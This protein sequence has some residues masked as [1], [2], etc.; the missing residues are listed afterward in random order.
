MHYK[1]DILHVLMYDVTC[2]I[3]VIFY[4]FWCT[5]SFLTILFGEVAVFNLQVCCRKWFDN[6][7]TMIIMVMM[8][9]GIIPGG[10]HSNRSR[11]EGAEWTRNLSTTFI[12]IIVKRVACASGLWD[13]VTESSSRPNTSLGKGTHFVF[14]SASCN[15]EWS[16]HST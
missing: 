1:C 8:M 15:Q 2:M 14:P 16:V 6:F 9:M 3:N 4:K 10:S 13:A 11:I 7:I 5:T 12:L